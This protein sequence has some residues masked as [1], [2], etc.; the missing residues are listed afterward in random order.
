[1]SFDGPEV[2][3]RILNKYLGKTVHGSGHRPNFVHKGSTPYRLTYVYFPYVFVSRDGRREEV[4]MVDEA[5]GLGCNRFSWLLW[6]FK[7]CV[8]SC[9]SSPWTRPVVTS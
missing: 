6:V 9:I 5:K 1:M 4:R 3:S 8:G 7:S 2:I